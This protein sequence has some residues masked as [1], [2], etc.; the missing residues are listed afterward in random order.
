MT[1]KP[2]G[3]GLGLTICRQIVEHFG[4]RIW[5]EPAKP[6]GTVFSFT[7][8]TALAPAGED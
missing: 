4:G 6:T 2:Q 3:W 8:P 7:L 5:V 1:G